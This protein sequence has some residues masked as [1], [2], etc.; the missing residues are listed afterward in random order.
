MQQV[1]YFGTSSTAKIKKR[2]VKDLG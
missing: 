1:Y 2:M